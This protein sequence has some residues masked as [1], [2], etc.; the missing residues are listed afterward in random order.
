MKIPD[1]LSIA[2]H[3]VVKQ[4]RDHNKTV[5]Q[6]YWQALI[7]R[8][9]SLKGHIPELKELLT[10]KNDLDITTTAPSVLL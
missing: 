8:F 3:A 4:L 7:I 9:L 2:R 5:Q 1:Q 10:K 6:G